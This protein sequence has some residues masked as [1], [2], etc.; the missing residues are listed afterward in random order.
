MREAWFASVL[1]CT[2]S[3]FAEGSSPTEPAAGLR[4]EQAVVC[5]GVVDRTPNGAADAFDADVG[6]LWCFTSIA[7]IQDET[8]ISHVWHQGGREVHGQQLT[9]RGTMWR[10]WSNKGIPSDGQGAWHV[11]IVTADGIVLK[12]VPFTIR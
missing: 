6:R 2:V 12:T 11:D 7:G 5:T 10:T 4:V 8:T 1:L 9:V 3:V